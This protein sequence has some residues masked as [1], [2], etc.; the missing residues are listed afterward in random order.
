M[1]G[2]VCMCLYVCVCVCG[3]VRECTCVLGICVYVSMPSFGGELFFGDL[4]KASV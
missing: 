4:E 2:Y 1:Y 3:R